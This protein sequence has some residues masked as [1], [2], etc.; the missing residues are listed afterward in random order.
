[1]A[2]LTDIRKVALLACITSAVDLIG[3]LWR[4]AP[5]VIA[6][7]SQVSSESW[8]AVPLALLTFIVTALLLVFYFALYRDEG[9]VQVSERLRLPARTAAFIL[10]ILLALQLAEWIKSPERPV[11]AL[12]GALETIAYI[13]LLAAL[14]RDS[15]DEPEEVRPVGS[16]LYVVTKVTVITWG[17]WVAFNLLRVLAL[18]YVYS[19]TRDYLISIGRDRPIFADMAK[20]IVPAFLTAACL[21]TAP[22]IVYRS[23]RDATA[24]AYTDPSGTTPPDEHL[25]DSSPGT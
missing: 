11:P 20:E 24:S 22:Y 10:G 8:R 6:I 7:A 9:S 13:L 12:L 16:L 4:A 5:N 21:F 23:I 1:M 3:Y 14:S 19:Q 25:P 17:V 18:P 15:G 2:W